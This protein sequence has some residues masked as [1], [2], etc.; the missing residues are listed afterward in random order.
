MR[1]LQIHA[2]VVSIDGNGVVLRGPSGSGKSDLAL[3]LIGD[4]AFLVADDRCDLA[5]INNAVVA[6]PPVE[7]AG[8]LEV[9]GLGVYR[10]EYV[11]T[12]PVALVVDLSSADAIERLPEAASCTDWG[13]AI[14]CIKLAPFEASATDKIQIAL[15]LESIS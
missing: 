2:T 10:L 1:P 8:L 7:I 13:P 6:S 5:T 3:R 4:G 9:R 14:P 11:S 15:R 12:T